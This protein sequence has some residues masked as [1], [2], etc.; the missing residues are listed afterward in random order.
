MLPAVRIYKF[1]TKQKAPLALFVWYSYRYM[2]QSGFTLIEL[3]VVIAIIGILAAVVLQRVNI[4][5]EKSVEA[6]I[7]T[8]M[9]SFYKNGMGEEIQ[10]ADFNVVCGQNGVATSSK[11]LQLVTSI[12]SYSNQ[13]VC[14]STTDEFAATAQIDAGTHWCVDSS[15]QQKEIQNALS[16]G[17]TQCP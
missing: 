7:I 13:F 2:K 9:D 12:T 6:N 8:S 15:G 14:N 4:A 17:V 5:R 3:L 10:S 16:P 1:Y 11:L